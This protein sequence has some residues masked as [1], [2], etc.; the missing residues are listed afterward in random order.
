[1]EH[2]QSLHV[3]AEEDTDKYKVLSWSIR[4]QQVKAG[5]GD[6]G[7]VKYMAENR[8][9]HARSNSLNACLLYFCPVPGAVL[10]SGDIAVNKTNNSSLLMGLHS[11]RESL[12]CENK[13]K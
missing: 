9:K 3:H 4:K 7:E 1:M 10:G 6:G 11:T 12:K 2:V 5:G 13:N 8:W